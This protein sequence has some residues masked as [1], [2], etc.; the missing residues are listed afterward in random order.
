VI[1]R[2]PTTAKSFVSRNLRISPLS[3]VVCGQFPLVERQPTGELPANMMIL[4]GCQTSKSFF[5]VFCP[6]SLL[7]D[8][9]YKGFPANVMILIA[10][11][12]GG[13]VGQSQG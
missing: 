10:R 13:F 7:E 8:V 11:C 6:L 12:E 4:I 9:I 3:D 2:P 5:Y 1:H